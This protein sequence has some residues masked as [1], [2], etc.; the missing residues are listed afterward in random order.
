MITALEVVAADQRA[1]GAVIS[2]VGLGVAVTK[3]MVCGMVVV[4]L[5][6]VVAAFSV[7]RSICQVPAVEVPGLA[8]LTV[9]VL[10]ERR[11]AL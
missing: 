6:V 8:F 1:A 2:A 10:K 5:L 7:L 11:T 3:V 9:T 4:A